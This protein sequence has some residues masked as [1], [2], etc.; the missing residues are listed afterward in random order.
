M[1]EPLFVITLSMLSG[2]ILFGFWVVFFASLMLIKR[3]IN[4]E[5]AN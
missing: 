5:D 3:G 1:S 4:P 2:L